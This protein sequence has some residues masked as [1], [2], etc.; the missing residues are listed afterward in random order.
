MLLNDLQSRNLIHPPPWLPSTTHYL[1]IMGSFAYGVAGDD[2]DS[3]IYGWAIPMKEMIFPH[4][5]G[6][7]PGF[8]KQIQR[9]EQWQEHHIKDES[10]GKEYDFS[11]YN[12]VKYFQLCMNNNPNMIDSLFVPERCVIH[13][14]AVG[15]IVRE[16]RKMFLHKG[17]WPKLRGYAY[18][19]LHKMVI[20]N[21]KPG[22]KRA[23]LIEEKGMDTK[24]AY[25]IVRL[26]L[27][28]E[29]ILTTGD[30]H[31]DQNSE[32][33]KAIRRGEWTQQRVEKFFEQKEHALNKAYE[34][35]KLPWGPD[36]K[37]IKELLLSCLEHHFG[38][39]KDAYVE[40]DRYKNALMKIMET[41]NNT[42]MGE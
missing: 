16:N 41:C 36:E 25:H 21:P 40:P 19:Q 23:K 8:G 37:V 24:F 13:C 11:V 1:C 18:S 38:S 28:A 27:Q 34:E 35:S 26:I 33:L 2:S 9:F 17:C 30:L 7:I 6:E 39:L 31:L 10:N 32:V 29:E 5:A 4:L 42:L 12:V 14:S 22:S 15:N 20:K 3:D